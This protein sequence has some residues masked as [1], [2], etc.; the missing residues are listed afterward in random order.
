MTFLDR[1]LGR[2]QRAISPATL[3]GTGADTLG[4]GTDAGVRV[5]AD[6]AFSLIAF[7]ACVRLLAADISTLPGKAYREVDDAREP[8]ERQPRWI[9][10][11]DAF[12][13]SITRIDHFSQVAVSLL[14]DGNA[15]TLCL[16]SVIEPSVLSVLDPTRV[17]VRK[18]GLYPEYHYRGRKPQVLG[19]DTILHTAI[20]RRPGDLRGMNPVRAAEEGIGLGVATQQ[21]AARMFGQGTMVPGFIEVPGETP[22][23]EIDRMAAELQKRH[24][25]WRKAG[26]MGFLTGGAKYTATGLTPKDADLGLMADRITEEMARLFGIPPHMIG[27][28]KPGAV[29]YASVEHRSIEYVTHTLRH[30]VEPIEASYSRLVP[31]DNRLAVGGSNTYFK[32]NMNALLRGDLASRFAAYGTALTNGIFSIDEVRA[33][34]DY[35]KVPG[36][37]VHRV[38]MQMQDITAPP[39]APAPAPDEP[40]AETDDEPAAA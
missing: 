20:F 17:V 36:G 19:P 26:L 14:T 38:Q 34:E 35:A 2:E 7:W 27:S 23:T 12:D 29:A 32:F 39:P 1:L 15:F 22:Q 24:G 33:L 30:Y 28:Q 16:P 13:P 6:T 3:F 10:Q 25:G 5:N 37:D 18:P 9:E 31:G 8:L 40:A 11:P 4:I 21:Y